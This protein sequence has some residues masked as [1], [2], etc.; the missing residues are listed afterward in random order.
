MDLG[1]FNPVDEG[2][3]MLMLLSLIFVF[4]GNPL[5][6]VDV[7]Y[8]GLQLHQ[9]LIMAICI[10]GVLQVKDSIVKIKQHN[11]MHDLFKDSLKVIY[12][13]FGCFLVFMFS[14]TDVMKNQIKYMLFSWAFIQSK[15]TVG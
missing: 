4:I 10:G 15:L 9:I 1:P 5:V 13:N 6:K 2:L 7:P 11:R 8:T 12:F 14:E 3:P